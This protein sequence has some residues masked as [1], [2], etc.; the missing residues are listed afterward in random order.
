MPAYLGHF[1]NIRC[2]FLAGDPT[3]SRAPKESKTTIFFRT[4]AKNTTCDLHSLSISSHAKCPKIILAACI[5]SHGIY[6][7][8]DDRRPGQD[9]PLAWLP[10][11]MF[12]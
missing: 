7:E 12:Y 11:G 1:F 2:R 4:G 8:L 3:S 9:V 10:V 6:T 5:R